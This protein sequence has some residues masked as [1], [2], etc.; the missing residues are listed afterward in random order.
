P[1][2]A[3]RIRKAKL[4]VRQGIA[5]S[6]S[7]MV[8][9]SSFA[10]LGGRVTPRA[11]NRNAPGRAGPAQLLLPDATGPGGAARDPGSGGAALAARA[12]ADG[13]G[14]RL[15]RAASAALSGRGTPG[16]RADAGA[17]G[18][19]ALACRDGEC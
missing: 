18:G 15:C 4:S 12:G 3:S 5:T 2:A 8:F 14:L 11:A 17:A 7:T 10:R 13:G 9:S 16:D 1:V 6:S 19:D